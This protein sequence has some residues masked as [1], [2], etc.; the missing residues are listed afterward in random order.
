MFTKLTPHKID[1]VLFQA[2]MFVVLI[3][4]SN[5]SLLKHEIYMV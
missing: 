4:Y 1:W 2:A 3:F 5:K